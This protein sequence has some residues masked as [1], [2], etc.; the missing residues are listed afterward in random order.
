MRR[1]A[2]SG[3]SVLAIALAIECVGSIAWCEEPASAPLDLKLEEKIATQLVQ[4]DV[5]LHGPPDALR[6]LTASD[7]TLV[8]GGRTV[9]DL[10]VDGTCAPA[11]ASGPSAGSAAALGPIPGKASYL[12]YFDNAHLTMGG[13][14]YSLEVARELIPR[15]LASGARVRIVSSAA[16]LTTYTTWTRDEKALL[17]GLARL[18]ADMVQFDSMSER[19]ASATEVL[20]RDARQIIKGNGPP[21][22]GSQLNMFTKYRQFMSTLRSLQKEEVRRAQTGLQRLAV[23]LASLT[24]AQ[25][26]KALVYFADTMRKNAGA[27]YVRSAFQDPALRAFESATI[28]AAGDGSGSILSNPAD[29]LPRFYQEL[30]TEAASAGIRFYSVEGQGIVASTI[31]QRDAQGTLISLAAETGGKAFLN[32]VGADTIAKGMFAD[33]SCYYLL[34]FKPGDFRVDKPLSV[35]VA[36]SRPKVQVQTRPQLVIPSDR[37]RSVT[38]LVAAYAGEIGR[39]ELEVRASLIPLAIEKHTLKAL[40]QVAVPPR[41]DPSTLATSWDIGATVVT[42]GEAGATFSKRVVSPPDGVPI[43]LEASIEVPTG[44]LSEVTAVVHE[45]TT[46]A[47][48]TSRIE[49]PILDAKRSRNVITESAVIQEGR[50]VMIRNDQASIVSGSVAV[51]EEVPLDRSRPVAI[52]TVVC[53]DPEHGAMTVDR[54]LIGEQTVE[55]GASPIDRSTGPCVQ[56][57]DMIPGSTLGAGRFR[58]RVVVRRGSEELALKERVFHVR[59][60]PEALPAAA[61]S[62]GS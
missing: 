43:V 17:D 34:S 36:V 40:V 47:V 8:V 24:E 33:L 13:R 3:V 14:A 37:T 6:G 21:G 26:P 12:F 4:L 1:T 23:T 19:E 25:S 2:N 10:L 22:P 48:G 61:T 59:G 39:G 31:S 11:D 51:P 41:H 46:D 15:F 45:V 16:A 44:A 9:N 49:I 55:F 56:L 29:V 62:P 27:H 30:L 42:R 60:D 38:R 58:Y 5:T 7:F 54:S 28:T 32:G 35:F 52:L 20:Q 18:K 50:A 57:R 53:G